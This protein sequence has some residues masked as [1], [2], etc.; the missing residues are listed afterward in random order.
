MESTVVTITAVEARHHVQHGIGGNGY[1]STLRIATMGS[2]RPI[3]A[4]RR[5]PTVAS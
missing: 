5:N 2:S 4:K 1:A 3:P